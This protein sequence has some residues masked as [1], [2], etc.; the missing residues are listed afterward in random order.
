MRVPVGP[1]LRRGLA[2]LGAAG[3]V[4]V[5]SAVLGASPAPAAPPAATT[6]PVTVLTSDFEDGTVQGWGTRSEVEAVAASTTLARSGSHSLAVS[7]RTTAWRGPSLDVLDTLEPG[8]GY[9]VEVWA[10]WAPGAGTA[11][12]RLSSERRVNGTPSY[13]NIVGDTD[14]TDAGWT[15]LRGYFTPEYPDAEFLSLYV[16]SAGS[17]ADFYVDDLTV[18]HVPTLPVQEDLPALRDVFAADWLTGAAVAPAE[19]EGDHGE[20]LAKHF[21]SVTTGND[22]KWDATEPTEGTFDF[23]QADRTVAW[24]QEHDVE[25]YGHTL[26]W[27]QQVPAWVFQDADG[28]ELTATPASK[29]LV[30]ERLEKHVR[31]VVGHYKGQVYAWDVANEVVDPAQSDGMRR[32]RW[33][34]L[35]GLDYLR[36]AFEVA[37]EVDPAAQLCINDYSTTDAAKR[38]KYFDLVKRLKSDGVPVDCVGHQ[39]HGNVDWPPAT[40][41]DTT[42]TLFEGLGVT[43]RVTEM[44]VSIYTGTAVTYASVPVEVMTR[45]A[46]RYKA[47]FQV[48]LK[49]AA[50]IDSVTFWGLADDTTWLKSFPTARRDLPLLFDEQLQAKPAYAA[51]VGLRTGVTPVLPAPPATD[52]G[53]PVSSTPASGTSATATSATA[54]SAAGACTARYTVTSSWQGGFQ[55][56]VTVTAGSRPIGGWSVSWTWPAGESLA[57]SSIWGGAAIIDGTRFTVESQGQTGV[58]AAGGTASIGFVGSS[59]GTPSVPTVTCTAG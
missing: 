23:S 43:Q 57:N 19:T 58:L 38:Q 18:S 22:M 45:Q 29:T 14:V 36:T 48:F 4:A 46:D 30:L 17:V 40:D 37:H 39:M 53:A 41:T 50:S 42:L 32:S 3:L 44:D 16:E 1:L 26:V 27:H 8:T 15:R 6:G 54:T 52:P 47:L 34:E 12:M 49:H 5:P 20:L 9:L 28:N 59:K 31:E 25:V 11:Q 21:N 24:A 56:E 13:L 2:A 33:Y 55:A 35:T 10:R 7:G 51:I